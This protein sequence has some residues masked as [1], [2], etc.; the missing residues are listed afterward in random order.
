M[1]VSLRARTHVCLQELVRA[2]VCACVV[3]EC[4]S[5]RMRKDKSQ[6]SGF[7]SR[8]PPR[9]N[10]DGVLRTPSAF[11]SKFPVAKGDFDGSRTNR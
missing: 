7:G 4:S 11:S 5:T 10:N 9:E 3:R 6:A 2:R 8:L 1:R